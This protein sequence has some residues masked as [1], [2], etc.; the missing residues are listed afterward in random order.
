MSTD[1]ER[2]DPRDQAPI[3]WNG[4]LWNDVTGDPRFDPSATHE[5]GIP[6]GQWSQYTVRDP[7]GRLLVDWNTSSALG[8]AMGY[9]NSAID[10]YAVPLAL[11]G[12]GAVAFGPGLLSNLT[13]GGDVLSGVNPT[14]FSS[15]TN[16]LGGAG[17]PASYWDMLAQAGGTATD[18]ADR[19]SVV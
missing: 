11:G 6:G 4:G 15:A 18:A 14:S 9:G 8:K 19:K 1:R 2:P 3:Q 17:T 13:G 16:M 12:L 10:R 5:G 7:Q